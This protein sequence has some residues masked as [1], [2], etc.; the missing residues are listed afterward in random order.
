MSQS[1]NLFTAARTKV[2]KKRRET[3]QRRTSV[4]RPGS[5]AAP[6]SVNRFEPMMLSQFLQLATRSRNMCIVL[7]ARIASW[8]LSGVCVFA[9]ENPPIS[10]QPAVKLCELEHDKIDESSGL[11]CSRRNP[12]LFWTH[13]DQGDKARLFAFGIDGRHLG[14]SQVEGADAED[15]EDL[16]SFSAK[17]KAYL[18]I[19]DLGD[20]DEQRAYCTI[21]IVPEPANP[22]KDTVVERRIDFTYEDG[23]HD[24]EAVGFD[25]TRGEFL[26]IEKRN[27]PRCRVYLLPWPRTRERAIARPICVIDAPFVTAMDISPDGVNAIVLTR[28][29]ARLFTR[30]PSETW[31]QALMRPPTIVRTPPRRQ[32]ETICFGSDGQTLFLTSEKVPT[33]LYRISPRAVDAP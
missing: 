13:N 18:A 23:P 5:L 19:G 2:L 25:V 32:G 8:C 33:P 16:V 14:T 24:C 28:L 1:L 26:L 4:G 29:D 21:Y 6:P 20:N 10:Y 31:A 30:S 11:A 22:K 7:F 9:M 27:D 15:W 3:N 17:G 12:D